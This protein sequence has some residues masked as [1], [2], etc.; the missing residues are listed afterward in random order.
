MQ[1][2][3]EH[4][5]P[6]AAHAFLDALPDRIK[7]ALVTYA[8]EIEYPVEAVLEIALSSFLDPDSISFADCRPLTGAERKAS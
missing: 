7:R 2:K 3:T 4:L 1:A 8:E 6:A 5:S